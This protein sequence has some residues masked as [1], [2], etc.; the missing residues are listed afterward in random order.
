MVQ[1][2]AVVSVTG[3]VIKMRTDTVCIHGDTPAADAAFSIGTAKPM[4]IE[5]PD[6]D[7]RR[8]QAT[9]D[10]IA[11]SEEV[12]GAGIGDD[13][14]YRFLDRTWM[15]RAALGAHGAAVNAPFPDRFVRLQGAGGLHQPGGDVACLEKGATEAFLVTQAPTAGQLPPGAPEYWKRAR[16]QYHEPD[17]PRDG[18]RS[19]PRDFSC[20]AGRWP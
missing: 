6:L 12:A 5:P 20:T 1:D 3:K 9:V 4:P 19:W 16:S 2:G 15:L 7:D 13:A 11:G 8:F 17:G 14:F 10:R 18:W